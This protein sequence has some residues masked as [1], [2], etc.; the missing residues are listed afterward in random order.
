MGKR[1]V[2][3]L[4]KDYMLQEGYK[5]GALGLTVSEIASFWNVGHRTLE[6]WMAN[7]PE[8][9]AQIDKGR[10]E[11]DLT[12]IQAL[13]Q[14]AKEGNITA[15]IFWLKNR[16]PDKWKDVHQLKGESL[17][18][19][20]IVIHNNGVKSNGDSLI[21]RIKNNSKTVSREVS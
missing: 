8:F 1:G 10:T 15:M 14:A 4:F 12:V 13:L 7:K 16:Q 5:L 21:D 11:A 2:K 9:K 20:N 18:D 19:T 17:G 6:R 3:T